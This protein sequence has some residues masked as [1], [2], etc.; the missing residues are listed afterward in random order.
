METNPDPHFC[1][2][3][4]RRK[5]CKINETKQSESKASSGET[6]DKSS[7]RVQFAAASNRRPQVTA[8]FRNSSKREP[9]DRCY[10]HNF[11]RFLPI[12]GKKF[13]AFLKNQR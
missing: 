2:I 11:L 6:V 8:I 5:V 1:L 12:F 10:E 13:G 9:G 3:L 4:H 7:F